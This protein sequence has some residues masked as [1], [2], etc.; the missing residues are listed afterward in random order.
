MEVTKILI[1]GGL[2]YLGTSII[3][4][5]LK[6]VPECEI[7]VLDSLMQKEDGSIP[8]LRDRRVNLVVGDVR[9]ESLL[10]SLVAK[11]NV[12]YALSAIVGAPACAKNPIVAEAVNFQHVKNVADEA[13]K[14]GVKVIYPNTNSVYGSSDEIVTEESPVKCLSV[15]AKTKLDAE[16]CVLN[17][18]GVSLRLA[19]LAGLSFRQR[20]D[21]LVNSMTLAAMSP[22]YV[23][24]YEQHFQRNYISVRDAARAFV[25][26]LK[27]YDV[28]S[29]NVYNTGNTKLNCSKLELAEHIK[30]YVPNFVIRSDEFHSDGDKRSYLVSNAKIEATGF[31]CEDDFD[32]IIPQILSGYKI[33]LECSTRY[34]NL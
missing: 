7:T 22:G 13:K 30:R 20:K 28:M 29:G 23:L 2:G 21:L 8:L 4:T 26:A 34:T 31:Q 32:V 27:N 3:E 10:R 9:D 5:L 14:H 25:H 16:S 33:L 12:V 17:A 6:E 24:L 1:T 18:G 19:T 11:S 15:Y